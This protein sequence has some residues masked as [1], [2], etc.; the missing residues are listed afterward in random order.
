MAAFFILPAFVLEA[1]ASSGENGDPGAPESI[2]ITILPEAISSTV[3]ITDS[4]AGK[5]SGEYTATGANGE[6]NGAANEQ[7]TSGIIDITPRPEDEQPDDNG[8]EGE[9]PAIE[10]PPVVQPPPPEQTA[11]PRPFTPPGTGEVLDNATSDDGKEFFTITTP[12]E[13]VFYLIIDRQRGTQNVY[14]LNAVTEADLLSLATI[15]ERP[16]PPV[17]E[18]PPVVVVP[19]PT[20]EPLPEPEPESSGNGMMAIVV[21]IVLGAGGAG[22]YFKVYRPKQQGG[23]DTGEFDGEDYGDFD[24]YADDDENQ[25]DYDSAD[26]DSDDTAAGGDGEDK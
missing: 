25:P 1:H 11:P 4:T 6:G 5:A 22:W 20:P 23:V 26:W 15:P 19:E 7:P 17:A 12:D 9:P 13:N 2:H 8:T 18:P 14:F 21:I 24:P 16:E 3:T 10:F